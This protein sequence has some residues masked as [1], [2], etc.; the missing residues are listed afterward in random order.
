VRTVEPFRTD[1]GR[2][3]ARLAFGLFL[4]TAGIGHFV[5]TDAFLAQVP[6]GLPAPRGVVWVSGA[7][8][9]LLGA[10]LLLLPRWRV[11]LGWAVAVFLAVVFP[12]NVAQAVTGTAAFGLDTDAARWTRLFFQPLLVAWVLW[13]TAAWRD[14]AALSRGVGGRDPARDGRPDD[15]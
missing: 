8:E 11:H 12:G 9:V 13:A 10:G 14:R 1:P 2:T 7:I 5:A 4:V 3:A 6:P 15:G